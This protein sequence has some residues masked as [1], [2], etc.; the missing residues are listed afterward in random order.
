MNGVDISEYQGLIDWATLVNHVGFVIIKVTEGKDYLDKQFSTNRQGARDAKM[1]RGYYHF[2]RFDSPGYNNTPEEEAD[3]FADMVGTNLQ[4]G[5]FVALDYEVTTTDEVAKC[6]RFRDRF[7]D[8]TG[9]K[10]GWLYSFISKFNAHDW[11]PIGDI[12]IWVAAP[13]YGVSANHDN[14]PIN[15]TYLMQQYGESPVDGSNGS[16]DL[17]HFW[18]DRAALEAYG[19]PIPP[20]PEPIP[21]T[22]EPLP[23]PTPEP[24]PEPTP[25]PVPEPLPTPPSLLDWITNL[26]KKIIE[27]LKGWKR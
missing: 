7:F 11:T 10:V 17:N 25:E 9:V 14:V 24:I 22:P 15:Y 3:W 19:V 21:P 16:T 27:W 23:T 2:A 20:T 6:K 8:R 1:C 5:E 13:S 12:G 26:I 18:G 4:P